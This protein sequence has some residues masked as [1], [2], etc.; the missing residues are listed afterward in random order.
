MIFHK[1][2]H[3]SHW[4]PSKNFYLYIY[5]DPRE[6]ATYYLLGLTIKHK[7]IYVGKGSGKRYLS[8]L[9]CRDKSNHTKN[10]YIA[11][12]LSGGVE[13]EIHIIYET[14]DEVVAYAKEA[15]II[16]LIGRACDSEGPLLNFPTCTTQSLS[17]DRHPF[18]GKHHSDSAKA[19]ISNAM[20]GINNPFYGRKH[21]DETRAKMHNRTMSMEN[22]IFLRNLY[23]GKSMPES[24][25]QKISQNTKGEL[26]C[27]FGKKKDRQEVLRAAIKKTK[28]RYTITH[29][30]VEFITYSLRL[31][32]LEHGGLDCRAL[33]RSL[34][35]K[36]THKGYRILSKI[37][38]SSNW[39][40][41]E[42]LLVEYCDK[43]KGYLQYTT[44]PSKIIKN[45]ET[46]LCSF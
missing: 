33:N 43:S 11:S 2:K 13:P 12:M 19:A 1:G 35:G 31:F 25:K 22:K 10:R 6:V 30:G 24:T 29:N 23:L 15:E 16:S 28:Y 39:Y 44:R 38:L 5:L 41:D 40:E 21:S 45:R 8:H 32:C 9:K 42:D 7:P 26:S 4:E 17:G 36:Y 46:H 18:Y 34:Y 37:P 14:D 27:H 20:T 3:L